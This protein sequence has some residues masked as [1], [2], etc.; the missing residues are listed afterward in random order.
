M[1]IAL[2][3]LLIM[4]AVIVA[5]GLLQAQHTYT[6][7]DIQEGGRLFGANCVLCHGPEGD[8]VPGIDLAHGRFR[9]KYSENALIN[10]IQNGIPG[11]GMPSNN[12]RDFQA[13]IVLAYLRSLATSGPPVTGHGDAARGKVLFGGK[14]NCASCHRVNGV[15]SRIG[16]DLSDI[17]GLRR[18]VEIERSLLEPNEEVLPQNR[19][20]RVVTSKGETISGRLL[21]I[22][23]FTVQILDS[24][25]RLLSL[26]RSDLRDSGFVKDS[27]MPSYRDKLS[28]QELA[29]VVAYL[30]T[31]KGL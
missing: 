9:Q 24:K 22:D 7:A 11:T 31:L 6:P 10:I 13:E 19:T 2:S 15:G 27:P 23:T 18:T 8:Q 17:G 28:S 26:Q 14:A 4:P 12:L 25:E 16:P 3:L 30:V 21:N 29:D 20:Y 5:P 1:K